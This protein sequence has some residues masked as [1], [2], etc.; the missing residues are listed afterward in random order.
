VFTTESAGE[1]ILKIDQHLGNL[2][3]RLA[4]LYSLTHGVDKLVVCIC[5]C[6]FSVGGIDGSEGRSQI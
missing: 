1:R 6:A 4:Y 3:K 2:W 5:R